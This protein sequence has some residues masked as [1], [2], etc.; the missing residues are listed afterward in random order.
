M[1]DNRRSGGKP[2]RISR[3]GAP[4]PKTPGPPVSINWVKAPDEPWPEG[5]GPSGDHIVRFKRKR[6]R[7]K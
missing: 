5:P 6:R 7:R 3:G 2:L 1:K 4:D